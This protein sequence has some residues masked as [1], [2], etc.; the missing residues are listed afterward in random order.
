MI[1]ASA[2]PLW[3]VVLADND[4]ELSLSFSNKRGQLPR[5]QMLGYSDSIRRAINRP[6]SPNIE[7]SFLN[8]LFYCAT[9]DFLQAL[10]EIE[11][12]LH[13]RI[14]ETKFANMV[15]TWY[16]SGI[17]YPAGAACLTDLPSTRI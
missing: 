15:G 6:L 7:Y 10:V 17:Y 5:W 12:S 2:N 13:P 11:I 14:A 3:Q 4:T 16:P 8:C 1:G 9:R